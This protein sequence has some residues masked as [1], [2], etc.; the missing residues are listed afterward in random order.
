[1]SAFD[2]RTIA[3]HRAGCLAILAVA[4][5]VSMLA[6]CAELRDE[7]PSPNDGTASVHGPGWSDPNSP[8]FHGQAIR[9]AAWDMS[10]CKTCHGPTYSGGTVDVSCRT[11]HSKP[12]GPENCTTC[13]GSDNA[14]PPRDINR[15]T[16]VLAPGVGA[17]QKHLLGGT[18]TDGIMCMECHTVPPAVYVPGHLDSPLPA[19]VMMN[20]VL[21]NTVTNEPTT[22]DYDL[23]LPV[24]TPSPAFNYDSLTC[25]TTYCHG[26]FKNGNPATLVVW[27]S[28]STTQAACGTCH[29]DVSKPTL[30]ERALPKTATQGGTH[31]NNLACANCHGDVVNA[32]LT[33]INKSKHMNGR[34]NVFGSERDF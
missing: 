16:N 18:Y 24:T 26:T 7:L 28:G 4:I 30:A 33:I 34:L 25:S 27:N 11:C 9:N 3:P 21:A 12:A 10:Q 15:N 14:A 23:I 22:I 8:N 2:T 13:H 31:P 32:S 1:M 17:H 29:G 6:G 19:E 20:G 5:A